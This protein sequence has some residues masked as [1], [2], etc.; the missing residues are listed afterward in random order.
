[1][2]N[3]M[4]Y[5]ANWPG[6]IWFCCLKSAPHGG[7]TPIADSARVLER[8]DPSIKTKFQER[9]V[10]YVRNYRDHLDLSYAN[11]FGTGER[12][13]IEMFCQAAGIQCEFGAGGQLR[14]SQ[15]CS[16]IAIHPRKKQAV[17]FN[18]AHL[19]HISSLE[20]RVADSLLSEFGEAGLPRN[21]Y[22]GD[23][24][25]IEMPDLDAIREAYRQETVTFS[26]REGDI[27]MLD[28]MQV[29][30]G[31]EPFSGERKIIVAMAEQ[32]SADTPSR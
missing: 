7:A 13:E 16:A 30:H 12:R 5:A 1:M 26:W 21:A 9:G 19:F 17:W 18:Q 6:K 15:R 8:I 23:G 25:R 4:S 3:E 31:R 2:H 14:T 20:S 11:V 22:Y 10:S 29:A 24:S 28:N 32:I 27:L